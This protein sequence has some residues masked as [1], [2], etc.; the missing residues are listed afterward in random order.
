MDSYNAARCEIEITDRRLIA[1]AR[2]CAGT[3]IVAATQTAGFV[4]GS[5]MEMIR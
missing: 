2:F 5:Y 4:E 1:N 3:H